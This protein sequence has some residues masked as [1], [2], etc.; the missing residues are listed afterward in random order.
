MLKLLTS[1]APPERYLLQKKMAGLV[2][3]AVNVWP[4]IGPW[5]HERYFLKGFEDIILSYKAISFPSFA[6]VSLFP[7]QP[8]P[9]VPETCVAPAEEHCQRKKNLLQNQV[10]LQGGFIKVSSLP[11][12]NHKGFLLLF[13]SLLYICKSIKMEIGCE[14]RRG[15]LFWLQTKLPSEQLQYCNYHNLC[16]SNV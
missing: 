5:G 15:E 8:L 16:F 7:L 9:S 1:L 3:K 10:L 13:S 4:A 14:E 2:L 6:F 12:N 11:E